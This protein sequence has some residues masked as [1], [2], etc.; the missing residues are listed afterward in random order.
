M[1]THWTRI[2]QRRVDRPDA[3]R[4]LR[5]CRRVAGCLWLGLLVLSAALASE[6]GAA[7][8]ELRV[9]LVVV[10]GNEPLP[11][12]LRHYENGQ[13]TN[14]AW[15]DVSTLHHYAFE[16]A[17]SFTSLFRLHASGLP[18]PRAKCRLAGTSVPVNLL[19]GPSREAEKNDEHH[20]ARSHSE[21]IARHDQGSG[22]RL[23]CC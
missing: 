1:R 8:G 11:R 3:P 4:A 23:S 15:S 13:V 2:R 5:S 10:D 17:S 20:A 6:V 16:A 9:L 19:A 18:G 14:L 12:S 22:V 21:T 7:T